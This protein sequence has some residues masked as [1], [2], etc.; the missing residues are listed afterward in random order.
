[1]VG[2]RGQIEEKEEKVKRERE[3]ETILRYP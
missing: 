3:E 1:L 2:V